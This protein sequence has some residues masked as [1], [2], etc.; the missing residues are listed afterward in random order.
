MNGT[1]MTI[2]ALF[3][4]ALQPMSARAVSGSGFRDGPLPAAMVVAPAETTGNSHIVLAQNQN[5]NENQS[6]NS[7]QN[8]NQ[9]ENQNQNLEVSVRSVCRACHAHG[10]DLIEAGLN[11]GAV[12]WHY[13]D[14]A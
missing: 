13:G 1:V 12:V 10:T 9:N 3:V 14:L 11:E 2:T 6:G 4:A 7:N 5:Q 8:E